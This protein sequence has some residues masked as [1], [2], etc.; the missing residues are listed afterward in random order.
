[1]QTAEM[2]SLCMK[3]SSSDQRVSVLQAANNELESRYN[4]H[5]LYKTKCI[6]WEFHLE[7]FLKNF[8]WWILH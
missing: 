2:N 1:M 7:I 5:A 4:Y 6:L 3:E 8:D